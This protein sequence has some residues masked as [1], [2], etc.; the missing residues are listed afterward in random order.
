[1]CQPVAFWSLKQ[2]ILLFHSF[3][4]WIIKAMFV[5]SEIFDSN[6]VFVFGMF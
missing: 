2:K 6:V 5:N 4:I 3:Q 1:M